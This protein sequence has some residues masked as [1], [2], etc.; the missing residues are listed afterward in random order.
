M[1]GQISESD[2]MFSV[3]RVMKFLSFSYL[4]CSREHINDPGN[5]GSEMKD[6]PEW[7]LK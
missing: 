7:S 4:E 3:A 6:H 5:V 1:L 2:K